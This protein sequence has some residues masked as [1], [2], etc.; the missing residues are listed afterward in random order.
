MQYFNNEKVYIVVM[1]IYSLCIMNTNSYAEHNKTKRRQT[2]CQDKMEQ[3]QWVRDLSQAEDSDLAAAEC[4]EDLEEALAS[5][6]AWAL[7]EDSAA[8]RLL[9]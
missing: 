4:G 3:G 9:L 2:K 7:A 8:R 6:E 1:N 5:E